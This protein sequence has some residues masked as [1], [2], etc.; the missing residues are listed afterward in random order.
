MA[1]S[2]SKDK[3]HQKRS[4]VLIDDLDEILDDSSASTHDADALMNDDDAIDQLL[5]EN[6]LGVEKRSDHEID[7]L[8]D[9]FADDSKAYGFERGGPEIARNVTQTNRPELSR[10]PETG[11]EN[12]SEEYD[13]FAE[14]D[15]FGEHDENEPVSNNASN[16]NEDDFTVAE[17]DISYDDNT[18]E[19]TDMFADDPELPDKNATAVRENPAGSLPGSA[20][21]AAADAAAAIQIKQLLKEQAELKQ[22]LD[23]LSV[24]KTADHGPDIERLHDAHQTFKSQIEQRIGRFRVIAYTSLGVAIAAAIL[25][26]VFGYAGWN[27][28]DQTEALAQRMVDYEE[29]QEVLLAKNNDQ[30]VD[31]INAKIDDQ[32]KVLDELSGQLA[33][34]TGSGQQE[35]APPSPLMTLNDKLASATEQQKALNDSI[36]S[37]D[38]R[39]KRLEKKLQRMP[40]AVSDKKS[41][42]ISASH[43]WSV[44]LVSYKQ[45]WYAK[46]KAAEFKKQGIPAEVVAVAVEG[47]PWFRLSVKGFKDKTK[48]QAY[49]ARVKKNFNLEA[50]WLSK[51]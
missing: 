24:A 43:P 27:T 46:R 9:A 39:I 48:A 47:Q 3:K 18:A 1:D 2:N 14:I 13:E 36:A 44:N 42:K 30:E 4:D 25:V 23:E 34:L 45:E 10:K 51:E 11:L 38:L 26:A 21:Q 19:E 33:A 49:A 17:F 5:R 32:N 20:G 8:E 15:E 28:S 22:R 12:R 16:A 50:V 41:G 7:T 6:T 35:N 29:S 31:K 40:R 37:L